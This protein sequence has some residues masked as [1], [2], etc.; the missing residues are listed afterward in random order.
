MG[1]ITCE[2]SIPICNY[3][4]APRYHGVS[5]N[6]VHICTVHVE[7]FERYV[8]SKNFRA[9]ELNGSNF[10]V[11]IG[12]EFKIHKGSRPTNGR[13][14]HHNEVG[15]EIANWKLHLGAMSV[16]AVETTRQVSNGPNCPFFGCMSHQP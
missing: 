12:R 6:Q 4:K 7:E 8:V 15:T 10:S 13:G 2:T 1:A 11:R 5:L 14:P 9:A 3:S 16:R